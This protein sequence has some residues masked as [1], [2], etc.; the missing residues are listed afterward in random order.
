MKAQLSAILFISILAFTSCSDELEQPRGFSKG[1]K[2]L[3]ELKVSPNFNWST[4]QAIEIT[5]TGLPVLQGV[6][7]AKATLIL[8][9][10]KEI[11]YS[12]FHAINE[13]LSLNISVP[14][15]ERSINLKFG[16]IEQTASIQNNKLS[17]SYIPVIPNEE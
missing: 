6:S 9:G 3:N 16:A 1:A 17:F 4:A 10:E 11:Y 7:P 2:N 5:I 12:G 14:S 8:K 13:N 15:T